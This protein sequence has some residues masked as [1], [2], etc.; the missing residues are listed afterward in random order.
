MGEPRLARLGAC[1]SACV[2]S[3]LGI[4]ALPMHTSDISSYVRACHSDFQIVHPFRFICIIMESLIANTMRTFYY[5]RKNLQ[6]F[7]ATKNVPASRHNLIRIRIANRYCV[8]LATLAS[9]KATRMKWQTCSNGI[10]APDT[11]FWASTN[12]CLS[13]RSLISRV[14]SREITN[15]KR[16]VPLMLSS[17]KP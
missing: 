13:L 12:Q 15:A 5:D 6:R 3:R 17:F 8:L 7:W 9:E 14:A 2:L 1:E 11:A 16:T 4:H 10:Y